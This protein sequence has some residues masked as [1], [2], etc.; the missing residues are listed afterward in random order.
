[1]RRTGLAILLAAMAWGATPCPAVTIG[2][3]VAQVCANSY[4]NW[5][6]ELYTGDGQGRTFT[7]AGSPRIPDPAYQHDLARDFILSSFAAMGYET[8][9]DPFSFFRFD[10][11]PYEGCNN[12]VAIKRGSGGTNVVVV[13]AHY[14]TVDASI[15]PHYETSPGADDNASGVACL[16]EAA[17]VL[18]GYAF[19][20]TIVFVAF[21]AEETGS[22]GAKHFVLAHTTGDLAAT[23][24]TT[25]HRP[26]IKSMLSID[27]IAYPGAAGTNLV[28]V[29]GG[30][31]DPAAPVRLALAQAIERY[32]ANGTVNEESTWQSDHHPFHMLGIDAAL[33]SEAGV[34]A[35]PNYHRATDSTAT[36]G[37]MDYRYAAENTKG[38]VGFLCEQARIL[39]PATVA[40]G[41]TGSGARLEWMA[42]PGMAYTVFAAASPDAAAAWQPVAFVAATNTTAARSVEVGAAAPH[43][44][45]R[46]VGE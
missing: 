24:A 36:P 19:R 40:I 21:D 17:R 8:W 22:N 28:A 15:H 27:T 14:D 12:V 18:Q 26:A 9:L 41:R 3:I 43:R 6:A 45:F 44:F 23:N 13:G 42:S 30:S 11:L 33:L 31:T 35:N 34:L 7:A 1:M 32:S 4:S 29:Y 10:Y 38:V 20:D 39:P 5:V 16:L 46:V 25:F 37:Y 2:E